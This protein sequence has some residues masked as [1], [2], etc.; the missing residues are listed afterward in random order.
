[1]SEKIYDVIIVGG[2]P[3]GLNAAIVLGRCQRKVILFDTGKQR[4]RMSTGIHNFITRDNILPGDFL[5][6]ARKEVARYGVVIV[7]AEIIDTVHTQDL[8][9]AKDNR[10][11]MYTG[12][13]LLIATGLRDI[14]PQFRELNLCMA[15]LFFIAPIV[16]AGK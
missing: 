7:K 13:K 5:T 14:I 4:N 11:R 10:Q 6:V 12:K 15:N 2:G 3:A 9:Y 1:M 8:F 16:M